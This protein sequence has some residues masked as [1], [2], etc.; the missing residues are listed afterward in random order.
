MGCEFAE[1]GDHIG[2]ALSSSG[3]HFLILAAMIR[4]C[5]SPFTQ[6]V[7]ANTLLTVVDSHRVERDI[8]IMGQRQNS[9]YSC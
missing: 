9:N 6:V 1:H 4:L 3:S 5:V 2:R 7:H 8:H